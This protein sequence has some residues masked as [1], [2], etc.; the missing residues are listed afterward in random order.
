MFVLLSN[1]WTDQNSRWDQ[2]VGNPFSRPALSTTV[3]T[4]LQVAYVRAPGSLEF[5]GIP[6]LI[7]GWGGQSL[8]FTGSIVAGYYPVFEQSAISQPTS[9]SYQ[10]PNVRN[11]TFDQHFSIPTNQPPGSISFPVSAISKWIGN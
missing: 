1:G 6:T 3:D 8:T 10:P 4:A 7:E 9:Q 2:P 5:H 11:F